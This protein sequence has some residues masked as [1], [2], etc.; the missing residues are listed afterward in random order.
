MSLNANWFSYLLIVASPILIILG[1][2]HFKPSPD[3]RGLDEGHMPVTQRGGDSLS[4]HVLQGI[5]IGFR[6]LL[7]GIAVSNDP[8]AQRHAT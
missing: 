5:A 2:K 1:V 6:L 3:D 8:S 4:D 7:V